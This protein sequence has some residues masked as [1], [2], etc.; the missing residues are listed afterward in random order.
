MK[1]YASITWLPLLLAAFIWSCQEQGDPSGLIV[2]D[3]SGLIIGAG[4][5]AS[6][7]HK[8]DCPGSPHCPGGGGGGGTED[9]TVTLATS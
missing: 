8:G 1:R 9:V 4:P 5:P 3:P 6:E 7:V 2:V